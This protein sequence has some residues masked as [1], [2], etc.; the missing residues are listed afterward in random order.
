MTTF[1]AFFFSSLCLIFLGQHEKSIHYSIAGLAV[2]MPACV[3]LYVEA[4]RD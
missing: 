1:F 3:I 4:T 2:M